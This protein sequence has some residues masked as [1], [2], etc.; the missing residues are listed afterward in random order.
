M[1]AERGSRTRARTRLGVLVALAASLALAGCGGSADP[2]TTPSPP[3][4]SPSS[5]STTPAPTPSAT[6]TP[7]PTVSVPPMPEAAKQHT[8]AGGEAFVKYYFD[9]I[10]AVRTGAPTRALQELSSSG[11]NSC[12][13]EQKRAGSG[14]TVRLL[15]AQSPAQ[16][17]T[18]PL[19]VTASVAAQ[20]AA[21]SEAPQ[22]FQFALTWAS[23]WRVAG[24]TSGSST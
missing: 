6:P 23:G 4:S 13:E 10:N 17:P 5:A 19:L 20:Q 24:Y 11:C 7:S 18:E 8:V 15:S 22:V 14:V 2:A 21:A 9:V 1:L 16:S 12:L 3:V